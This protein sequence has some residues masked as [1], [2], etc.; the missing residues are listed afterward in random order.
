MQSLH[1]F[2][3]DVAERQERLRERRGEAAFR[4]LEKVRPDLA[5]RVVGNDRDPYHVVEKN[6]QWD[7]F[8]LFIESCWYAPIG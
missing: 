8:V 4:Q 2:Y 5:K 7:R 6:E 3:A 1:D